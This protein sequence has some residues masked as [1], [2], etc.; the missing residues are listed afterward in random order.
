MEFSHIPVLLN[1]TIEGLNVNPNG[2]YV[3]GTA[4]GGG[5]SSEILK[6]LTSG[7]LIC[8]DQDPDAICTLTERFKKNENAL[9]VKGNFADIKE[10]LEQRG[11]FRVDGV[12]LDIG[13]SS[14]QLDTSERGFS[15]HEDAP[16]DMRMSQKGA[17]A[18]DL[19]NSLPY[20]ELKKIIYDYGEE[21]YAPSIAKR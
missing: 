12:L 7:R 20:D 11:V 9:I 10:L 3:D 2:I 5:H 21:K 14:H 18:A 8:I 6:C 15:F 16:L 1:Q 4:G 19:I 17:T 13:V